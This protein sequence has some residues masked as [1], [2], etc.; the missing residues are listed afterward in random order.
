MVT[1][2][3]LVAV[4]FVLYLL[5][6]YVY[7]KT[8]ERGLVKA[9][10][11]TPTP[12]RRLYDG[13][14]FVP[15]NK[16]VLF[17]HHFASIAGAAPIVGPA[18]AMAWGWL[19]A[20]LWVWFGNILIGSIH[21]YLSLMASVRYDGR[22]IPWI[23]GKLLTKR[24]GLL[25]QIFILFTLILVVA[26]FASVISQIFIKIPSVAT[27]SLFFIVTAL[28]TGWL[29]YRVK[30]GFGLSTVIGLILIGLSIAIAP[31]FPIVLHS[32]QW[33]LVLFVYIVIA[34]S[35]PVWI[36]LQPR[37]YLN[38][39]ILWGGLAIGGI[40]L[41]IAFRH[42][43]LPAFT[44]WS[45]PVIGGKPS[46]FW[47]TIPLII[48]CGSLSG[49]HSI[50]AS[51]TTSKQLANEKDGLFVGFGGMYT[52]GF[53]STVVITSIAAFGLGAL[54]KSA[55][56][57]AALAGG[58]GHWINSVG[59]PIGIF[60]KSY[61]QATYI[62]LRLP[63]QAMAVFASLWVAAFTL[64]TL[65]TVDRLG[66]FVWTELMEP[67]RQQGKLYNILTNKWIASL[68]VAG[69]GVW[70]AM[71]GAWKVIWPA[72]GGANQMLA[73]IALFT[74]STWVVKYLS[75]SLWYRVAVLAP[76]IFLWVTVT[77]AL[78]WYLF[79]VIPSYRAMHPGQALFLA[80]IIFIE[81]A[82]NILLVYEFFKVFSRRKTYRAM[83]EER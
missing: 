9:N 79:T 69:L 1:T 28:I 55:A 63:L 56:S 58:Y 5:F 18:I 8:L 7:G 76:T 38:A 25:F 78:F 75:S 42:I 64:T 39:Y 77:S 29:L 73:S 66:R 19:P 20:I 22:S 32:T 15:A 14:D 30:L 62:A 35:L 65:D 82:L 21:D 11:E 27:A 12:A 74:V 80:L 48:A 53:L 33:I 45:A 51:G 47:P 54:G 46:P 41:L 49:F 50:V 61:A 83:P 36:L 59:G 10:K 17:G 13:M 43:T 4:G 40:A 24:T 81:I 57:P 68:P 23:A 44:M 60:S 71:G 26:A 70:M 2:S 72:F 37:D 3:V 16:Y 6:Y 31:K 67:F 52:E 34:S